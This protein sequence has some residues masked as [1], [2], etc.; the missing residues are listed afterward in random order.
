MVFADFLCFFELSSEN[1]NILTYKGHQK[2]YLSFFSQA[3]VKTNKFC[4]SGAP[5]VTV[6]GGFI[7]QK[8]QQQRPPAA[9]LIS[10]SNMMPTVPPPNE[11]TLPK[12]KSKRPPSASKKKKETP[13]ATSVTGADSSVY[14]KNRFKHSRPV[15]VGAPT[16]LPDVKRPKTALDMI[17]SNYNSVSSPNHGLIDNTLTS[18]EMSER[19]AAAGVA[20]APTPVYTAVH[21]SGEMSAAPAFAVVS[22]QQQQQPDAVQKLKVQQQIQKLQQQ[23]QQQNSLRGPFCPNCR[24]SDTCIASHNCFKCLN[25]NQQFSNTAAGTTNPTIPSHSAKAFYSLAHMPQVPGSAPPAPVAAA[26]KRRPTSSKSKKKKQVE[27]VDLVSDS[28]GEDDD[29]GDVSSTSVANTSGKIAERM[30]MQGGSL[31]ATKTTSNSRTTTPTPPPTSGVS[32]SPSPAPDNT[33]GDYKFECGKAMFGELQGETMADTRC[34]DNRIYLSLQ[35]QMVRDGSLTPEK[36]TL[37]VGHND[38]QQILIHFGRAPSFVAIETSSRF[39]EVA[40]KRIGKEVL[41]PGATDP[42]KRYIILA[43]KSAFKLDAEAS[44]EL[45]TVVSC[46][47]Q[48]AKINVLNLKMAQKLIAESTL[49]V[50]QKEECFGNSKPK[51]DGPVETLFHYQKGAKSGGGIP[52]TTEDR[53]CLAEGTYLNDIII[54]FYLKYLYED[55]LTEDQRSRTYIFNTFFYKRLTQKQGTKFSPDQM[56]GLVKKWTRNVDVF[57][58]DFVVIPVNE[59]CHWY[60]VVICFPGRQFVAE[61]E[62]SEKEEE[63]EED[64]VTVGADFMK[65]ESKSDEDQDKTKSNGNGVSSASSPSLTTTTSSTATNPATTT[66]TTTSCKNTEPSTEAEEKNNATDKPTEATTTTPSISTSSGKE[67]VVYKQAYEIDDFVRPCILIFDSLVGSGHSRVFTNLRHYL[68]VEWAHRRPNQP[69]RSFDKTNMKGCYPKVPRQNNDCDCGVFLLQYVESFFS[70]QSIK[71]FRIPVHLESW[72]TQEYVSKKRQSIQTL[73]N[74]LA[75]KEQKEKD[76]AAASKQNT[77][78]SS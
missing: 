38:V 16:G 67:K 3:F 17:S 23:Q 42:R 64:E 40:C 24:M 15:L 66:T 78:S 57:E 18:S 65:S 77:S 48:W 72:F 27:T 69:A 22:Q 54:D 8:G 20:C 14:I 4:F 37:S 76:E 12:V 49:D 62:L 73:I 11:P 44:V 60:L 59:H 70:S 39:A 58:K 56:H 50:N 31:P 13:D 71:S 1:I 45:S 75:E 33:P 10:G 29:D 35:C 43:L 6:A 46:L 5:N 26:P 36:Y 21:G 47:S 61:D 53:A 9:S 63:E 55:V 7:P 68:T 34:G 74:T 28:E 52:V 41:V 2:G 19:Y 51:P 32:P 30:K 25:C